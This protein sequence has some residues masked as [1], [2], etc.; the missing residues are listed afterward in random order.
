MSATTYSQQQMHQADRLSAAIAK[1]PDE[2]RP[3]FARIVEAIMLGAE[4]MQPREEARA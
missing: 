4:L 2:M 3:A 1:I